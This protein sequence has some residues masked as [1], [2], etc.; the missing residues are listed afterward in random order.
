MKVPRVQDI[1]MQKDYD[2]LLKSKEKITRSSPIVPTW[3][4]DK[5]QKISRKP[6][7]AVRPLYTETKS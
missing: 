5:A 3:A 7:E 4:Y 1:E 6:S 2:S